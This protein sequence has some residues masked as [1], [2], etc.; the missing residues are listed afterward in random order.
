MAKHVREIV[1]TASG[2]MAYSGPMFAPGTKYV[3]RAPLFVVHEIL[4]VALRLSR[5]VREALQTPEVQVSISTHTMSLLVKL[6]QLAEH[7]PHL[8]ELKMAEGV[9][10]M[11][12]RT[13]HNG[14]DIAKHHGL[15]GNQI[16]QSAHAIALVVMPDALRAQMEIEDKRNAKP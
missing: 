10:E 8:A 16:A 4:R 2:Y 12:A 1:L 3:D 14:Q 6:L 7:Y 5:H 11:I 15:L 9:Y 13:F